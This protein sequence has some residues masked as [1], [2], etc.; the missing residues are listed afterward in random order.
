MIGKREPRW[1]RAAFPRRKSASTRFA[2]ECHQF[3]RPVGEFQ[4]LQWKLADMAIQLNAAW[5]GIAPRPVPTRSLIPLRA[6]QAKVFASK[7]AIKVSNATLQ[8]FGARGYSRDYPM[9]RMT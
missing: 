4:G 9:E 6:A 3:G 1:G 2:R 5:L 8:M 7:M